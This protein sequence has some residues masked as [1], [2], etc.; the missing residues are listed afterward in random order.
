MFFKGFQSDYIKR[1]SQVC[2]THIVESKDS[3]GSGDL[4]ESSKESDE[5]DESGESESGESGEAEYKRNSI[6][7]DSDDSEDDD[8]DDS[9]DSAVENNSKDEDSSD[10]EQEGSTEHDTNTRGKVI[11][12]T[13]GD[14]AKAAL[15][16]KIE[17]KSDII[18]SLPQ[19]TEEASSSEEKT[20]AES[21]DKR[22]GATLKNLFTALADG[23]AQAS[24]SGEE[25]AL[26]KKSQSTNFVKQVSKVIKDES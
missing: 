16:N 20:T 2:F 17:R 11:T 18:H 7:R 9:V 22:T 19:N 15:D 24:G 1:C 10:G 12:D 6:P 14:I 3:S 4:P 26:K 25:L 23:E 21:K 13:M 5:N 8:D